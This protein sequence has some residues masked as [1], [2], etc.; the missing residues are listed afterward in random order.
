MPTEYDEL[1]K[2]L[3]SLQLGGVLSYHKAGSKLTHY[4]LREGD[5]GII[6]AIT[7]AEI[8]KQKNEQRQNDIKKLAFHT[9]LPVE[10]LEGYLESK[11]EV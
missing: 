7:E 10:V 3:T 8:T 5:V 11:G 1:R 4:Q 2:Q 9:G 6:L